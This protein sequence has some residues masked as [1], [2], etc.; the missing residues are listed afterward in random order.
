MKKPTMQGDLLDDSLP[1]LQ[2]LQQHP[3]WVLWRYE[4]R[5]GK[6]TKVPYSAIT[7]KRAAV[8]NPATWA[9]YVKARAV[10]ARFSDQYDGLGFVFD[11]DTIPLTGVD[12]DHCVNPDSS[13]DA[14][15]Q[16]I[17]HQ[18]AGYAEYSPSGTGIHVYVQGTVSHGFHKKVPGAPHAQAAI[19]TYST[20]RY[21][22]VTGQHVP[23]TP[24][25]IEDGASTL[26]VLYE[27]FATP[28]PTKNAQQEQLSQHTNIPR[29]ADEL[30]TP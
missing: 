13:I 2:E 14:W 1:A 23:G 7:R 25:T 20:G 4:E 19:E 30:L 8:D 12:L 17:L 16:E 28:Q 24:T 18:L 10:L 21:F 15:A 3:H 27:R 26:A 9:S 11:S 29:V 5:D 22:I 6:A